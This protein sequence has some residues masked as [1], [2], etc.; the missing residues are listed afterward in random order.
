MN[1][2]GDL[3]VKIEK[4]GKEPETNSGFRFREVKIINF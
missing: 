4:F 3:Y 2:K 1:F